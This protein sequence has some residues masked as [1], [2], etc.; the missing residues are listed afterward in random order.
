MQIDYKSIYKYKL[1][2]SLIEIALA[3]NCILL[4]WLLKIELNH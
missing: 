1:V 2:L 3:I 4:K